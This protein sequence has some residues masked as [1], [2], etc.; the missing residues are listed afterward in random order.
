MWKVG[1]AGGEK[2]QISVMLTFDG[3][4]LI[5]EATTNQCGNPNQAGS[6]QK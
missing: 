1:I 4:S 5:A 3:G 6:Q 2:R